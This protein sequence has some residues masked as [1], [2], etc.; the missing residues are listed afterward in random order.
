MACAHQQK[1][2][3]CLAGLPEGH[4]T[5]QLGAGAKRALEGTV[6]R[7]ARAQD[8]LPVHKGNAAL[9]ACD[10][11]PCQVRIYAGI[12][13]GNVP[14]SFNARLVD[15]EHWSVKGTR[16]K[17]SFELAYLNQA[18]RSCC[19]PDLL[20]IF[21]CL[22]H[23]T[24]DDLHAMQVE[25]YLNSLEGVGAAEEF[26]P[27]DSPHAAASPASSEHALS[28]EHYFSTPR[29]QQM[30]PGSEATQLTSSP[31]PGL[32]SPPNSGVRCLL[33]CIPASMWH[34]SCG[35]TQRSAVCVHEASH[36]CHACQARV[37]ACAPRLLRD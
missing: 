7:P 2:G 37:A 20:Y 12:S 23:V 36:V 34:S 6:E 1:K 29:E 11:L 18:S 9:Q 10:C 15:H 14:A 26:S 32:S 3:K 35:P 16:Q 19:A 5:K 21:T 33:M 25:N 28:E 27:D 31:L 8:R 30:T 13:E 24:D 17:V 4:L 22:L